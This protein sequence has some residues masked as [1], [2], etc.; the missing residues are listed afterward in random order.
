MENFQNGLIQEWY[1]LEN[2]IQEIKKKIL[3]LNLDEDEV[4]IQPGPWC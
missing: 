1:L 2:G 4:L 3:F